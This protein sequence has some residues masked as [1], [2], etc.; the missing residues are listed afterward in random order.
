MV[1]AMVWMVRAIVWM[2]RAAHQLFPFQL[3]NLL[4]V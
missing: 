1:R 4:W 2:F 3:Q